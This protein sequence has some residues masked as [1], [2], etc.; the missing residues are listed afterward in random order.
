MGEEQNFLGGDEEKQQDAKWN[1]FHFHNHLLNWIS[2]SAQHWQARDYP[3]SFEALTLVYTDCYGFF[4]GEGEKAEIDTLFEAA[5][6]ANNAYTTYNANWINK[7]VRE[8]AYTPPTDIYDALLKF[9]RALLEL[10]TK[11]KLTIPQIK[12]GDA[13]A[14]SA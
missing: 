9:R 5:L 8:G 10:M 2:L 3:S 1:L 6:T 7:K 12:K 11:H 14:G 13:G 4:T